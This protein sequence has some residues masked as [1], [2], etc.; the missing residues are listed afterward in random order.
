MRDNHVR[1]LCSVLNVDIVYETA[2]GSLTAFF[3]N[4][5]ESPL[6]QSQ[7]LRQIMREGTAA[8]SSIFLRHNTYDCYFAGLHAGDGYIYMGPMAHQRLT[9]QDVPCI[10]H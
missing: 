5:K 4:S 7:A 2:D 9:S 3:D 1:I 6:M 8:Q 10:W